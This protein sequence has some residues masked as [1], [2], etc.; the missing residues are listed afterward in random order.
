MDWV[1]W[2]PVRYV[3]IPRARSFGVTSF[4]VDAR[5]EQR[6]AVESVTRDFSVRA[7]GP[8]LL[9]D[10]DA[11]AQPL[12]GFALVR[13]QPSLFERM[14]VASTHDAFD[15]VPDPLS[16]W[17]LRT[18]FRQLPNPPPDSGLRDAESLRVRHN[19]AVT[20]GD[21][22][23]A[24]RLR[25]ELF[26]GADTSVQRSYT[27]GVELLGLRLE[28][29][30]STLLTLYFTT[31]AALPTDVPFSVSSHVEAPPRSSLVQKDA[32]AWDVGMPFVIPTSLWRPGFIYSAVTEITRRPGRER[33]DGAFRG[34]LAPT[35]LVAAER[36]LLVLGER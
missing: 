35:P 23:E 28:R 18:H 8:F 31:S 15:V 27:D 29:N 34:P 11:P 26:R 20:R 2:R 25:Q 12:Q 4:W 22:A 36:P 30:A 13:R 32:L 3:G 16:T 1:L 21:A 19:V 17:E 5:F 10:I 6:A 14:F 24:E 9:A 7:F 33:Y